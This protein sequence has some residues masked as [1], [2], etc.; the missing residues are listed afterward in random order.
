MSYLSK[1]EID[2][3]V[4]TGKLSDKHDEDS[5]FNDAKVE[6]K[7]KKEKKKIEDSTK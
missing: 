6:T 1:E 3:L 7:D 5:N 4:T 2:E